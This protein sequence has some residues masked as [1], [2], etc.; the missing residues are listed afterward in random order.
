SEVSRAIARKTRG[1]VARRCLPATPQ[2]SGAAGGSPPSSA[3]PIDRVMRELHEAVELERRVK[4][5][6]LR[7]RDEGIAPLS[8]REPAAF[9]E[10]EERRVGRLVAGG[11]RAARLADHLGR[12]LHVED[13]VADLEREADGVAVALERRQQAQV[14]AARGL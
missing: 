13:V 6:R 10:T 12:A 11:V 5:A 3:Q 14:L 7:Q 1:A 4:V 8:L 9:V 2:R